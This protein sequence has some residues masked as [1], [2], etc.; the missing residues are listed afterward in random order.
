MIAENGRDYKDIPHITE[1]DD[2]FIGWAIGYDKG[3]YKSN[4]ADWILF[5]WK[6][7]DQR[8]S[9]CY[10]YAGLAGVDG[11][12]PITL[13]PDIEGAYLMVFTATDAEGRVGS[14]ETT[15][16]AAKRS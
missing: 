1:G 15:V 7:G 6:Q 2:D 4:S 13:T 12:E 8:W 9:S 10:G 14:C 3:E 11:L 16:Q 5:D